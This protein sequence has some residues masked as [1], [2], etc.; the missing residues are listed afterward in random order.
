MLE[1]LDLPPEDLPTEWEPEYEEWRKWVKEGLYRLRND[2]TCHFFSTHAPV[3]RGAT[4]GLGNGAYSPTGETYLY[5]ANYQ[6]HREQVLPKSCF[7]RERLFRPR[8]IGMDSIE[9]TVM[10]TCRDLRQQD[11]DA[12]AEAYAV[13]LPGGQGWKLRPELSELAANLWNPR[14]S[15]DGKDGASPA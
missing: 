3:V 10:Y 9:V 11:E 8:G 14:I 2:S 12:G 5:V 15:E 4:V 1:F 7:S 13:P 6:T